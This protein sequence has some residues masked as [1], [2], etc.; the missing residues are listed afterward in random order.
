MVKSLDFFKENGYL[1][2]E[3][4]FSKEMIAQ[5]L[6]DAKS[7]FFRQFLIKG[8][9]SSENSI[10]D[11][12][13][14]SF[15][16]CLYKLFEE[17]LECFVNCGKQVQHLI[18]LHRLSLDEKIIEKITELGIKTPNISTRPVLFFNHPKLAK[19]KVFYKVDA[20]QDWRSMQGSLNSI[21]VWVPLIDINI[22]L[23]ALE[24]I[25]KSHLW[26]LRTDHIDNGFGMVS[27]SE[28][29]NQSLLSVEVNAGDVLIFSSFLVH[30]S[31]NNISNAPRW[32]CHFRYNDLDDITF[33]E[34]KYAHAY[35]YKPVEELITKDFPQLED[36]LKIYK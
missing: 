32:S 29:E 31:G 17:D 35:I 2:L 16:S 13:E 10:D 28:E 5:V 18:S 25:P 12:N 34:R 22:R 15:N 4:F 14:D 20:H 6:K 27:L 21:V 11:I 3:A 23:G 8:Y 19:Q 1:H 36:V 30:Q 26:G 7:T 33:I 9:L 24:I